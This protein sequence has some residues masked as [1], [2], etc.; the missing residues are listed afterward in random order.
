[1]VAAF[2]AVLPP[3]GDLAIA[4]AT[5]EGAPPAQI[6]QVERLYA[7]TTTPA[8]FRPRAA[9]AAFIAGTELVALGLVPAPL[10]HPKTAADVLLNAP[11]RSLNLIGLGRKP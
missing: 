9:I 3:G 2:V 8:T 11:A 4:H 1:M 6:A 7:G 10:W 5:V